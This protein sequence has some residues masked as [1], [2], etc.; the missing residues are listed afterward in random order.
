[1]GWRPRGP[2]GPP[3]FDAMPRIRQHVNPLKSDLLEIADVARVAAPPGQALDVELGA[4]EAHFLVDLGRADRETLHVGVE[5]RREL[6][7]W[8]NAELAR[9]GLSNVR[10]VFANMSVDM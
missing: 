1:M 5:I 2:E 9:G 10:L 4:A 6:V 3:D 8:T 7:T